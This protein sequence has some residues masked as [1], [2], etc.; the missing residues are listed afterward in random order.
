MSL[1]SGRTGA[2]RGAAAGPGRQRAG[3]SVGRAIVQRGRAWRG[4]RL[5][6]LPAVDGARGAA[7][8]R[9]QGAGG[10]CRRGVRAGCVGAGGWSVNRSACRVCCC[11]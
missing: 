3:N 5:E 6:R 1:L 7:V 9:L 11:R 4:R 10:L 2:G 8:R